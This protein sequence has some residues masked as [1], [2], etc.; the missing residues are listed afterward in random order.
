MDLTQVA[1]FHVAPGYDPAD[2]DSWV[3]ENRSADVDHDERGITIR[4][5]RADETSLVGAGSASLR[6]DNAGGHYCTANPYSRWYERLAQGC[7]ARWGT[8]SGA[9]AFSTPATNGL[10]SPDVGTSWT[11]E[12]VLSEWSVSSGTAQKVMPTANVAT[13]ALLNGADARNGD[14]VFTLMSPVVAT[15]AAL[16]FGLQARYTDAN[17]HVYFVVELGLSGAVSAQ[18]RRRYGGS[19]TTL[20]STTLGWT[21]SASQRITARCQWDGHRLRLRVWPEASAEPTTWD[22][23]AEDTSCGGSKVGLYPWRVSGN[24]NTNPVFHFDNLEI[25]AVEIVGTV[26]EWPVEWDDTAAVSWANIEISGISE[27]LGVGQ[28]PLMSP[29]RRQLSGLDIFTQGYWPLEDAP[30]VTSA[31]NAVVGKPT[32]TIIDGT[33]GATTGPPGAASALTLNTAEVSRVKGT[34]P[35]WTTDQDGYACMFYVTM[36]APVS[37]GIGKRLMEVTATGTITRWTVDINDTALTVTAYLADGSVSFTAGPTAHGLDVT[38]P[39]AI[40]LETIQDG[41]NVDWALTM[42]VVGS[43]SFGSMFGTYGGVVDRAT[44]GTAWAPVN[45]TVISHMWIGDDQLPFVNSTFML[46]SAAYPGELASDRAARLADEAGIFIGIEPGASEALG[47]QK[48]GTF[49]AGMRSLEAADMGIQYETGAYLAY[50]PRTARYNRSTWMTWT[51]GD[52]GDITGRPRPVDNNQRIRNRWT[53]TREDGGEAVA[54]DAA[55]IARSGPRPDIAT[56]NIHDPARLAAHASWR[57]HLGVWPEYRWPSLEVDFT[58]SPSQLALWRGRPFAPRV[59]VTGIPA[60]GPIGTD[61]DVIVEGWTQ[62]I[63]SH[64]WKVTASCSP[65]RP[66]DV[67]V[68]G[69]ARRDSSSTVLVPAAAAGVSPL[70]L[71]TVNPASTWSTTAEPYDQVISGEVVTVTSMG[72]ASGSGPFLQTA[73]VTRAVNDIAKDLP[74]GSTARLATPARYAL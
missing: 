26:E 64:S 61:A 3:W 48:T 15:G 49:G 41:G 20:A 36:P 50:R 67:A 24:T 58:D 46:V 25:E 29:I 17:D 1:R 4:G 57:V 38:Q 47:T 43:T 44:S 7:P 66:W 23:L 14:A 52:D 19:N 40:Q 6:V 72:A 59:T 69:T 22:T 8:I 62:E 33:F 65:A 54:E 63:T 37:G 70:T 45:G 27:R 21:Y 35:S 42:H 30:G 16:R 73:T 68:Y 32:A 12:G 10:G 39:W 11:L 5:G 13:T 53:L 51:I 9:A 2:P 31:T 74:I 71:S 60:Q 34:V 56:I 18:I 55:H 28:E